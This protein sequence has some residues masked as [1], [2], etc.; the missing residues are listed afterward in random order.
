M[1]HQLITKAFKVGAGAF[2]SRHRIGV[3]WM[4]WSPNRRPKPTPKPSFHLN[5]MYNDHYVPRD[6]RSRKL[7]Q[8]PKNILDEFA[9]SKLRLRLSLANW[10]KEICDSIGGEVK[11]HL[12]PRF[13][14]WVA[15]NR[16]N[17][18]TGLLCGGHKLNLSGLWWRV[19]CRIGSRQRWSDY[20]PVLKTIKFHDFF[21]LERTT[22]GFHTLV[23][24][25]NGGLI[26]V[27]QIGFP[28]CRRSGA[29]LRDPKLERFAEVSSEDRKDF[30]AVT[31]Q[32]RGRPFFFFLCY[33]KCLLLIVGT[34]A[35]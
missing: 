33:W 20:P 9:N 15:L 35:S 28:N 7:Y 6:S 17:G 4:S 26:S 24:I 22:R 18:S 11:H 16:S 5:D 21:R 29:L 12:C 27:E 19:S 3:H 14:W 2:Q 32:D 10:W 8:D 1:T 30:E 13:S 31:C 25:R 23:P 34:D